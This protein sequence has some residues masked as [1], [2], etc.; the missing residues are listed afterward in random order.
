MAENIS[1]FNPLALA[2]LLGAISLLPLVLMITTSFLKIS[3][4][5]MLTRNA[6][7]VQQTPPNMALYG[8]A[9]AATIF[10]MAPVFDGMQTR[11]QEKP[12]DT[13]NAERLESSLQYGIKPLT[14][15][16]LRN[17]DPD[18]ETHLMENS[19]RMWPKA[20]SDKIINQ[21]DNLLILIP[22]F[23]L[24]ELQNG[25]KIAFLIFIPFLVVDLIVSNVLLALGMQMVSPMTISLPLKI[26]LFVMVSGWTRLLDG[27]FYSYM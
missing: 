14:D 15:F 17:S 21:R 6:I 4:V 11:F 7:G 24:S 18:L 20:L 19:Q 22:S 27:L 13:T 2:I 23:V 16:M 3:M 8:I 25:F 9:L 10:V 1:S 12:I 5:L 26:L